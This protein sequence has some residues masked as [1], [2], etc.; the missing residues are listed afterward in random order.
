MTEHKF[1]YSDIKFVINNSRKNFFNNDIINFLRSTNTSINMT[2][3]IKILFTN[4]TKSNKM[5]LTLVNEKTNQLNEFVTKK[6]QKVLYGKYNND[7]KYIIKTV[8]N[9]RQE[10]NSTRKR[11]VFKLYENKQF[12]N[13]QSSGILPVF[14]YNNTKY[15]LMMNERKYN[16]DDKEWK[17]KGYSDF[18]G[19]IEYQDQTLFEAAL[20]E[21]NEETNFK[22]DKLL[23]KDLLENNIIDSI[24]SDKY[25]NKSKNIVNAQTKSI[26]FIIDFGEISKDTINYLCKYGLY[27]FIHNTPSTI[28]SNFRYKFFKIDN[29]YNSFYTRTHVLKDDNNVKYGQPH[30]RLQ[31]Y[32]IK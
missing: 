8:N 13:I 6:D 10:D 2:K 18:G 22:F 25:N 30:P 12:F 16:K 9:E 7:I 3:Q 17:W 24:I 26:I 20:R 11:R 15:F 19:K 4:I 23:N 28:K 21:F 14:K 27:T 5:G 31:L 32:N 1:I 29:L